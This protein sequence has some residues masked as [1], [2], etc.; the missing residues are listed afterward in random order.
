MTTTVDTPTLTDERLRE[1]LVTLGNTG[2]QVAVT[3]TE[4]GVTGHPGRAGRCP[5]A[6]WL[7]ATCGGEPLVD[8]GH[9]DLHLDEDGLMLRADTPPAVDQFIKWFDAGMWPHLEAP[10]DGEE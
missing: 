3:L 5:V 1:L 9:V 10:D 2:Y 8:N 4:A 6:H 7:I